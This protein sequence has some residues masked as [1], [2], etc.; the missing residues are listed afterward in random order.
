M[1]RAVSVDRATLLV[2]HHVPAVIPAD[3]ILTLAKGGTMECGRQRPFLIHNEQY[4]VLWR[5]QQ[6]VA[7][8]EARLP[9]AGSV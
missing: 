9:V 5:R 4:A 2:A 6:A 3:E 7:I 1:R 8:C